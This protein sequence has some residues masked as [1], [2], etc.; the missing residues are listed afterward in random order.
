MPSPPVDSRYG[1]LAR[2]KEYAKEKG[3]EPLSPEER[4][5]FLKILA[6]FTNL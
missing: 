4:E 6:E 2:A 1:R 5:E 3:W